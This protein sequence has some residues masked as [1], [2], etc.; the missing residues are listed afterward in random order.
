MGGVSGGE[1]VLVADLEV[2]SPDSDFTHLMLPEQVP[3]I[4]GAV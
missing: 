4:A 3:L 1:Q 2:F